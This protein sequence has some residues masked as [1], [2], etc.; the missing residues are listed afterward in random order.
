MTRERMELFLTATAVASA[1]EHRLRASSLAA[2]TNWD[3]RM[4]EL[5]AQYG[6][7]DV[8]QPSF[9]G[10]YRV[11]PMS[12]EFWQGQPRSFARSHAYRRRD[13]DR[14]SRE[15][16]NGFPARSRMPISRVVPTA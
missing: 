14:R 6:Q 12:I 10:G 8:P 11:I 4:E 3:R 15:A 7:G 1:R 13:G 16:W 2:E 5:T 9:W